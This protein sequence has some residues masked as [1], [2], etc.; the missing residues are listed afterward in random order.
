MTT[1][2]NL[3]LKGTWPHDGLLEQLR[4]P[5]FFSVDS[6][7]ISRFVITDIKPLNDSTLTH[8]ISGNLT[9]KG[10]TNNISFPARV[11]MSTSSVHAKASFIIDR[12]DWDI[13]FGSKTFYPELIPIKTISNNIVL[14]IE[15]M[16]DVQ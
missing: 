15:L 6:F 14:E 2:E 12:A 5:D 1:M 9:I 10:I 16:A 4:S 13:R 11:V 8:T 7:P 3:D